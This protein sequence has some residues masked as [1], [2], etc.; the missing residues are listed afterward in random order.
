MNE[1]IEKLKYYRMVDFVKFDG[2]WFPV[3][4]YGDNKLIIGT[5]DLWN[6]LAKHAE[7]FE[8]GT[9]YMIFHP[10]NDS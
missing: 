3:L 6:V 10:T 5:S 1:E 8:E 4:K 9:K 2:H 7:G